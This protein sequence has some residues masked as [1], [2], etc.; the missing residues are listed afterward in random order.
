MKKVG[1]KKIV[2]GFAHQ[3]LIYFWEEKKKRKSNF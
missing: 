3:T 1:V 2:L